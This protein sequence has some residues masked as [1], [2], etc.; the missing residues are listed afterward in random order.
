[1]KKTIVP[2][3]VH[4]HFSFLDGFS[5]IPDI[6]KRAKEIGAPAVAITDHGNMHGVSDFYKE[7]KK[8]GIKPIIGIEA[9][10]TLGSRFKKE[11]DEFDKPYYH[12]ILLAKNDVGLRN[13]YMLSSLSWK[14]EAFY[15]KPRIDMEI[16]E[17]YS[18]GVIATSACL[19][20]PTLQMLLKAD[21]ARA[22]E[23]TKRFVDVFGEDFYIEIQNHGLKEQAETNPTLLRLADELGVKTI[24]TN[25]SHYAYKEDAVY[26]DVLLAISQDKKL[27]DPTRMSFENNEFYIKSYEETK[28]MFPE[29]IWDESIANTLEIADKCSV[30]M[31][32]KGYHL[33][34]V[35]VPDG[36]ESSKDY[37][38]SICR[39]GIEEL[40]TKK[41]KPWTEEY[42]KQLTYELEVID[43]MGFNDYFLIVL[44]FIQWAKS[45]GI[46]IGAGRGSAAGSIAAYLSKITALDPIEH[47]LYFE[48]FLNPERVELPDVDIDIEKERRHEVFEYLREKYGYDRS[49]NIATF[50]TLKAKFALADVMRV[51]GLSADESLKLRKLIPDSHVDESLEKI[52]EDVEEFR[53]VINSSYAYKQVYE[54]ARKLL[55][56]PRNTGMH[57]AGLIIANDSITSFAPTFETVDKDTGEAITVCQFEKK[58]SDH[59]GLVKMDLLGLKTLDIIKH[60]ENAIRKEN[61]DFA[62]EDVPKTDEAVFELFASGQTSCVFQFESDGMQSYLKKLAPHKMV[63]LL[64]MNALYRPGP[65]DFID[66]YINNKYSPQDVTYEHPLLKPILEETYGIIVFQ[67]QVM[68]IF[69]ELAGFSLGRADLVRR[70]IGK[71][72]QNVLEHELRILKEGDEEAGVIG[73]RKN[74]VPDAVTDSVVEKIKT[75]ANYAFNKAHSACYSDIAYQTA[76]LKVYYPSEFM[77]ANMTVALGDTKELKKLIQIARGELK[78]QVLPPHVNQSFV[79]FVSTKSGIRFSFQGVEGIGK[80]AAQK[81]VEEREKNGDFTSLEDFCSRLGKKGGLQEKVVLNLIRVGAF[82]FLKQ[83]RH[84]LVEKAKQL[85]DYERELKPSNYEGEDFFSQI[86]SVPMQELL[87]P[88]IEEKGKESEMEIAQWERELIYFYLTV[89]PMKNYSGLMDVQF[90]HTLDSLEREFE[91]GNVPKKKNI[92]VFGVTGNMDRQTSKAGNP[93]GAGQIESVDKFVPLNAYRKRFEELHDSPIFDKVRQ[94]ALLVAQCA[95]DEKLS[96]VVQGYIP[97]RAFEGR[98]AIEC[99][100]MLLSIIGKKEMSSAKKYGKRNNIENILMNQQVVRVS[101]EKDLSSYNMEM[102]GAYQF[103]QSLP[104]G[105]ATLSLLLPSGK[106]MKLLG[107]ELV[108]N[109]ENLEEIRDIFMGC[110]VEVVTVPRS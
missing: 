82:D 72:M 36:F 13:L 38:E 104:L 48:R 63:D 74:G 67:E 52:Y 23:E 85:L 86:F 42:E 78:L 9:Y 84:T 103:A 100:Q 83:S 69:Q 64:A 40:F 91:K 50:G 8:E 19:G 51:M 44:D 71:K 61:P 18:E 70:A 5:S 54:Y 46:Y 94:P 66:D 31:G 106:E 41:G 90:V 17:R 34:E 10:Y 11:R 97:A 7:C 6:V 62:I 105:N 27:D 12:L 1:M 22:Y 25:D 49:A 96:L 45:Q 43:T 24:I 58:M 65:I 4:S 101:L 59:A 33:P 39:K 47:G 32:F 16:L 20:G 77:A 107:V 89:D 99:E 21:Y 29:E 60:S 95:S 109:D 102:L 15:Y 98:S 108:P 81:I 76:Y 35:P 2:L 68:K 53:E 57:A 87:Y 92:L 56:T 28:E 26:Q 93:Y 3:H 80:K 30:D 73:A 37:F 14:K 55:G 75:F 88:E 79:E 110:P